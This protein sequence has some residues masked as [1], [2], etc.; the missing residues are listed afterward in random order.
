MSKIR[1]FLDEHIHANLSTILQKRG[2]DVIHAQEFQ[3]QGRTDF[4]Q[5]ESEQVII[6][7]C[8][9]ST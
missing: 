6:D 7:A 2:Y 9:V 8:S 3:R 1:L 5:L 4:E